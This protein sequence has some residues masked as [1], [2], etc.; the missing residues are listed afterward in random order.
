MYNLYIK[1]GGTKRYTKLG[2]GPHNCF[3][4]CYQFGWVTKFQVLNLPALIANIVKGI[5][6]G[7]GT[8]DH[9]IQ[10]ENKMLVFKVCFVI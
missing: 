10:K 2:T 9:E 8:H 1:G 3:N 5:G 7:L 6:Y 4:G